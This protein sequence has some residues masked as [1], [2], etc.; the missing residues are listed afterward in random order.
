[1]VRNVTPTSQALRRLGKILHDA[2]AYAV[3]STPGLRRVT[4]AVLM[5]GKP[6]KPLLKPLFKL[7]SSARGQCYEDWLGREDP[8]VWF[9]QRRVTGP[10]REDP[11]P[12]AVACISHDRLRSWQADL[13]DLRGGKDS[14]E[15]RAREL[16]ALPDNAQITR[17]YYEAVSAVESEENEE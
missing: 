17:S 16:L 11:L 1:M 15:K 6:V 14:L 2:P 8:V 13:A 10:S 7:F 5:A 9:R 12:E 3:A 4:Q